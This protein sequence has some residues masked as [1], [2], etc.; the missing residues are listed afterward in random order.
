[1]LTSFFRKSKP[2]NFLLVGL[3]STLFYGFFN[4]WGIEDGFSWVFLAKK[5][6]LL[7]IFLTLLFLSNFTLQKNK[8][9]SRHT[10]VL[11]LFAAFTISF[12]QILTDGQ[13]LLAGLFT[14]LGLRRTLALQT[15]QS[16]SKKIF[17]AFFF[18]ALAILF[19]PTT[20]I[21]MLVPVFGILIHASQNY[22]HWLIPF[23][24]IFAVFILKTS[25]SLL[26]ANEFF[27]PLSLFDFAFPTVENYAQPQ[28]LWPL[29]VLLV[30]AVCMLF[31]FFI[32]TGKATQKEKYSG[33][34][35]IIMVLTAIGTILFSPQKTGTE[36]LFFII[37]VVL[38]GGKY[39]E[40]RNHSSLKEIVL[41]SLTVL[42]LFFALYFK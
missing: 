12:A 30:F 15:G 33:N 34:L 23:A 25:F 18:L 28:I 11:F 42:S 38:I 16:L 40:K 36:L 5:V 6:G 3:L 41:L 8:T 24:G 32:V 13:V 20:V 9:E 21:F 27:N 35:L 19:F 2:V 4:F 31:N 22:K 39:F 1:M 37:P 26:I 10:F 14:V 7:F 29:I 17:E